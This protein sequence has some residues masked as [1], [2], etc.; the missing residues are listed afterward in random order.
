LHAAYFQHAT[1]P[2]TKS[3]PYEKQ[4]FLFRSKRT[5]E[6]AAEHVV[7]RRHGQKDEVF[8]KSWK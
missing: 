4:V 6:R 8:H 1:A 2:K 7:Q 5:T 3:G